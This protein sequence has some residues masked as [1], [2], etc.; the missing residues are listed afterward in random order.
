MYSSDDLEIKNMPNAMK[1][2]SVF[3][4]Y[5][6]LLKVLLS[7]QVMLVFDLTL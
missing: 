4:V 2:A 3:E 1:L 5:P 6:L 7:T